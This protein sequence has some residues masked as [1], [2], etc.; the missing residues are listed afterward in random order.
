[1]L[2]T[3]A[4]VAVALVIGVVAW[5]KKPSVAPPE[6]PP[7]TPATVQPPQEPAKKPELRF[8][9]DVYRGNTFFA[10][11]PTPFQL[12]EQGR[13]RAAV[14]ATHHA[15][16]I[17]ATEPGAVTE[18][19]RTDPRAEESAFAYPS[20]PD[21]KRAGL[22][23][24]A[25]PAG[26]HVFLLA[27]SSSGPVSAERLG[28]KPGEPW[29]R[30]PYDT[31]IRVA[32]GRVEVLVKGRDVEPGGSVADPEGEVVARLKKLL[33]AATEDVTVEGVVIAVK[34]R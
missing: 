1:V 9:L 15:T 2:A 31:V 24:F 26:T 27:V 28:L 5:P 10:D 4:L 11:Y 18:L 17:L 25:A 34:R 12:G 23:K 16:L 32:G 29:P 21:P 13:V 6:N 3:G 8:A 22:M 14:P 7:P 20:P 19:S 30:L 33:R